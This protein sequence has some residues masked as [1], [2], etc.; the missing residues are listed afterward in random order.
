MSA[1]T[2]I[3]V[4]ESFYSIQGEGPY[5]GQPSVFLRVS[6]CNLSCGWMDDLADY[7]PGDEPQGDADWVCD[8]IDVWRSAS[9]TPTPRE[10]I[11]EWRDRGWL[12]H[13]TTG[14]ANLVLTGGEPL[15]RAN[16]ER[17]IEFIEVLI[18]DEC[19]TQ[20]FIE[21]ET[22]GSQT[23]MPEFQSFIQQANV[24]L[25]LENSGMPVDERLNSTAI[26][27]LRDGPHGTT[28]KF[29]VAS[30]DDLPEIQ[31]L[32]DTHSIPDSMITLMPAGQS[33]RDLR[34]TY[35][36]VAD[37]AKNEG[38]SFSPRLQVDVWGEVTGV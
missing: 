25:K 8:T 34:V 28:F 21:V 2:S 29:V 6:G 9:S 26:R 7:E 38:Y 23:P 20:P 13:L 36:V 30:A 12:K 5:A 18:A 32:A 33:Q 17:L 16:Q 37:V 4:A 10:L 31:A 11:D 15:M 22:N 14:S 35:P 24:S 27:A 1:P 3:P 19:R